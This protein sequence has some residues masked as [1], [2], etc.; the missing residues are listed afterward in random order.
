MA[1][2]R[3]RSTLVLAIGITAWCGAV[4]LTPG[5]IAAAKRHEHVSP[6]TIAALVLYLGAAI[7][8][9]AGLAP[10]ARASGDPR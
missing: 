6:R 5:E 9:L 3:S 2:S 10:S 1:R 4:A 8:V 7:L